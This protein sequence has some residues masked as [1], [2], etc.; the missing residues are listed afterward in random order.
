[1]NI[2][3]RVRVLHGKEEGI[4][5]K[6]VDNKTVEIEIEEGFTFPILI[7][8]LV[9]ITSQED[10]YFSKEENI[11]RPEEKKDIHAEKGI[12]LALEQSEDSKKYHIHLINNTDLDILITISKKEGKLKYGGIFRGIVQSRNT[13]QVLEFRTGILSSYNELYCQ[14]LLFNQRPGALKSPIGR[15][16]RM[17]RLL[18]G[19]ETQN[20]PILDRAAWVKQLDEQGEEEIMNAPKEESTINEPPPSE[21]DLHADALGI[22]ED[23]LSASEILEQQLKVFND[24]FDRAIVNSLPEITFIHGVGQGTLKNRIVKEIRK[25]KEVTFW[26]DAKKEKFGYGATKIVL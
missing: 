6:V 17:A 10:I 1:M 12:F 20:A 9:L 3:D 11:H 4:V 24:A 25:R 19:K 7:S 14:I 26:Q 18:A 2:G 22:D 21:V 5:T 8:D 15:Q 13:V 16:V 23:K